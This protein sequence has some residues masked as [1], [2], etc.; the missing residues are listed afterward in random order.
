MG[1]AGERDA[2]TGHSVTFSK[3]ELQKY[4]ATPISRQRSISFI[5]NLDLVSKQS[6]GH[7]GSMTPQIGA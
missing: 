7:F 2:P 1:A 6:S 5:N 3:G 4:A